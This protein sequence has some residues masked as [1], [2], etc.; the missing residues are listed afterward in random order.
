[1]KVHRMPQRSDEWFQVRLGKI[2]GTSFSTMAAG[3]PE[4]FKKLC[5]RVLSE[6]RTGCPCDSVPVTPA[7][8]RGIELEHTARRE[9]E[10]QEFCI[11][12][13]VGFLEKDDLLGVSPDG[14]VGDDG[15]VEIKCP[16]Q[17]THEAYLDKKEPWRQYR[18]QIQGALWVSGREWWDFVSYC[19]AYAPVGKH[20]A[21]WRVLP[22]A[23]AFKKLE[24][25]AARCRKFIRERLEK[26][27]HHD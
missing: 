5:Y 21:V 6:R 15:G 26:E 22:D 17:E 19:P 9:Y 12:E 7:M 18:W 4:T 27:A 8:Q 20:I 2:T 16:K 13:E 25:G 11:V 14:L 3:K 24:D 1:M 23:E 10:R